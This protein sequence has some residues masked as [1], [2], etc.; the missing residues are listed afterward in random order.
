MV[1]RYRATLDQ[2]A[3]LARQAMPDL[4]RIAECGLDGSPED[5]RRARWACTWVR[6][7]L[8][9]SRQLDEAEVL[10]AQL[11]DEEAAARPSPEQDHG[12]A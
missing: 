1:A 10:L 12:P 2:Y 8:S 4:E 7:H 9:A 11:K 5:V 6:D 3:Q